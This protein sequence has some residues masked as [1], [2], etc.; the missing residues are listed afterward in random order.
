MTYKNE[1]KR[2]PC[3]FCYQNDGGGW[4]KTGRDK[5]TDGGKEGEIQ[6]ISFQNGKLI[7]F[8]KKEKEKKGEKEEATT[9]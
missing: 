4:P 7:L 1:K 2:G 3:T 6:F 8:R 9:F 5:P